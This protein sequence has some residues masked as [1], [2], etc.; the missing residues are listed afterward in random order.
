MKVSAINSLGGKRANPNFLLQSMT[1]PSGLSKDFFEKSQP[2][3]NISSPTAP[4]FRGAPWR[5]NIGKLEYATEI[6]GKEAISIFENF[7]P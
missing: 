1:K 2:D 4:S 3:Q 6:T 7:R 5:L